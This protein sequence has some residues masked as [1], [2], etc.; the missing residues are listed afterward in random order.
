MAF[1]LQSLIVPLGLLCAG[2]ALGFW[3]G[4]TAGRLKELLGDQDN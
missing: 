4:R 1:D 2:Y 3:H